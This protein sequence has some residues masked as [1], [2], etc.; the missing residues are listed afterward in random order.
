ME[1]IATS[2]Q[3]GKTAFF[4]RLKPIGQGSLI[5]VRV[6]TADAPEIPL[7]SLLNQPYGDWEVVPEA[8]DRYGLE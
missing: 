2:G 4:S 1:V 8:K 6:D 7:A 3:T 5:M